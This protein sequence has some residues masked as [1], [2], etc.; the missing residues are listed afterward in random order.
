MEVRCIYRRKKYKTDQDNKW[1]ET[2][3][4]ENGAFTEIAVE[5]RLSTG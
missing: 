2:S 3:A 4:T 5:N 1:V